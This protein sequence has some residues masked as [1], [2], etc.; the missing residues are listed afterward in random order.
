MISKTIIICGDA[1]DAIFRGLDGDIRSG[2]RALV[3]VQPAAYLDSHQ[4][5]IYCFFA[6]HFQYLGRKF[7]LMI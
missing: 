7:A 4:V 3:L 5:R 1:M 6:W 2:K